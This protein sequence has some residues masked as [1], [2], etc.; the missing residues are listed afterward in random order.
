LTRLPDGRTRDGTGLE[1]TAF[2]ARWA[3]VLAGA[4]N[5]QT[6]IEKG[7]RS[8]GHFKIEIR[9]PATSGRGSTLLKSA[10]AELQALLGTFAAVR[11][12]P[13]ESTELQ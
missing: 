13:I 10:P 12:L 2:G 6:A 11:V 3:G 1:T 5:L 7:G 4:Q 9:L 8:T